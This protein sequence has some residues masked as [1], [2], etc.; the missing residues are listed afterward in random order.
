MKENATVDIT[1]I[2]SHATLN[3]DGEAAVVA[4][5]VI[6]LGVHALLMPLQLRLCR[7][8]GVH[9]LLMALQLVQLSL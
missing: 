2:F 5:L 1:A 3:V 7:V 8:L 4:D 6:D 9:A